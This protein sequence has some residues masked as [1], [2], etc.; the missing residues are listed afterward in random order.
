MLQLNDT[1]KKTVI[2]QDKREKTG[3]LGTV[4]NINHPTVKNHDKYKSFVESIKGAG[5]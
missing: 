2:D 5:H 3:F 1:Q 4:P